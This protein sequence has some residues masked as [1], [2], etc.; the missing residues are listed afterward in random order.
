MSLPFYNPHGGSDTSFFGSIRS[1][2]LR[3]TNK[4]R[5]KFWS[6]TSSALDVVDKNVAQPALKIRNEVVDTTVTAGK[7]VLSGLKIGTVILVLIGGFM[8]YLY[9]KPFLPRRSE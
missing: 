3:E 2:A 6:A 4:I 1:A 8:L 7:S 9:I 5:A